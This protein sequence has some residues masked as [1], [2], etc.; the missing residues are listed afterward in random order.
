MRAKAGV[1]DDVYG[2]VLQAELDWHKGA[3]HWLGEKAI[4]SSI[5]RVRPL[6]SITNKKT[7]KGAAAWY[8]HNDE[9]INMGRMKSTKNKRG[10]VTF[11][12]E[13]GHHMDHDGRAC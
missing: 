9:Q 5:S 6:K 8:S 10:A 2:Y 3:K 11:R 4:I 13:Y 12:H 1:L 7:G